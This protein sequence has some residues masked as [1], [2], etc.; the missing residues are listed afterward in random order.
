M[1][2]VASQTTRFIEV[3]QNVGVSGGFCR[4]RAPDSEREPGDRLV[5]RP[6][7]GQRRRLQ[8]ELFDLKAPD[9]RVALTEPSLDEAL[10][11]GVVHPG[12]REVWGELVGLRVEPEAGH[13]RLQCLVQS[14]QFRAALPDADP[15]H[16]DVLLG[17]E[18]TEAADLHLERVDARRLDGVVGCIREFGEAVLV[19]VAE[20]L[21]RDVGLRGVGESQDVGL[22]ERL[23]C[24]GERLGEVV[25]E[26]D[27]EEQAHG[28]SVVG[29]NPKGCVRHARRPPAREPTLRGRGCSTGRVTLTPLKRKDRPMTDDSPN[30]DR[31]H[32]FSE[33]QGLPEEYDD[34]SLDPPELK[35]DPSKVD[36]VDSR[37]L[38][39]ILDKRN[40]A[41][42]AVDVESL[43]DVG[44]SYMQINRYEE[45]TETFGRAAQFAEDDSKEE[46]EAWVNKG[47][48]HAQ[49]DEFDEAIGAYQEALRIDEDSEHAASAETNLAYALWE[50]GRTEEALEHAENAVE[51]DPRFPQAW[52]NRG[53][54]LLERGLAEDAVDCFNNAQRLG[55]RNPELLEEKVRA[56]EELGREDE[57]EEIRERAEEL[58]REAEQQMV[59][60]Y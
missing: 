28:V 60:D 52:Y 4:H 29:L 41:S 26:V 22:P 5:L 1:I 44:L 14:G 38:A 54:F 11:A 2:S 55:M 18:G 58:R 31:P 43:I 56:L 50:F 17:G 36:P 24:G 46:Q 8:A 13:R 16:R 42:D 51:K 21:Q 34:F 45:A 9:C 57:A 30:E 33:G 35:V 39:D 25:G 32:R 27:G 48:A 12:Q 3:S 47:A 59:D 53:F 49:L 19:D 20:E 23:L 15:E 7:V 10:I 6:V 40:I 37:V